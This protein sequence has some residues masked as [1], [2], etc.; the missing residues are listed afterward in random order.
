[1]GCLHGDVDIGGISLGNSSNNLAVRRVNDV[2]SGKTV[3][4]WPTTLK[5]GETDMVF[6]L[7]E[8]VNLLLMKRPL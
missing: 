1:M 3:S 6:P 4:S 5:L 8:A 7:A 2:A